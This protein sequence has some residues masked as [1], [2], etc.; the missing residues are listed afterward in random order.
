MPDRRSHIR[1]GGQA[2]VRDSLDY[3]SSPAQISVQV[4]A[5]PEPMILVRDAGIG[6]PEEDRERAFERF[7]RLAPTVMPTKAG[8][9]LGLFISRALARGMGGDVV[10][11]ESDPG[12]GTTTA[13]KLPQQEPPDGDS[14]AA[15]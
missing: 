8:S 11:V 6:I 12:N 14:T 5:G 2:R 15:P 1:I 13:I 3:N 4:E 7:V 10:I 9:G